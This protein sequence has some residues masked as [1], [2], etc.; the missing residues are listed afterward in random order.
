MVLLS[1]VEWGGNEENKALGEGEGPSRQRGSLGWV[2]AIG[3]THRAESR[4]LCGES[5]GS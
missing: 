3:E 1:D 2:G 4:E 5:R